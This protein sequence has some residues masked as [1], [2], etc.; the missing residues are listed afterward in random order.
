MLAVGKIHVENT[1]AVCFQS[2]NAMHGGLVSPRYATDK[3]I[4]LTCAEPGDYGGAQTG[5]PGLVVT[6]CISSPFRAAGS[7]RTGTRQLSS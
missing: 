5:K 6:A 1:P 3:S 4:Y 7:L 2:R